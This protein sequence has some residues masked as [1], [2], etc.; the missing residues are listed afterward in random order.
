MND[1]N[2]QSIFLYPI[3]TLTGVIGAILTFVG[4]LEAI[5]ATLGLALSLILIGIGVMGWF[6]SQKKMSLSN[7]IQYSII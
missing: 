4:S 2:N 5:V 6:V 3:I 1:N 7:G